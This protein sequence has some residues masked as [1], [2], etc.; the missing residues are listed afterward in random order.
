MEPNTNAKYEIEV[1]YPTYNKTYYSVKPPQPLGSSS[2][3]YPF[4]RIVDTEG[5]THIFNMNYVHRLEYKPIN[6]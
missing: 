4:Y 2:G 3:S 6:T 5:K 1:T